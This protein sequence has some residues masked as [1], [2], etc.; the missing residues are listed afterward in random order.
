MAS[1]RTIFWRIIALVWAWSIGALIGA[2]VMI[3]GTLYAILDIILLALGSSG[4]RTP[5]SGPVKRT[6]MWWFQLHKY[7]FGFADGFE[8]LP[9]V[10]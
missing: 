6:L 4:K 1:A 3:V 2:V 8:L 7:A 5:L 9:D 10:T